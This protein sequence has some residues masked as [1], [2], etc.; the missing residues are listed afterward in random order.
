L[1]LEQQSAIQEAV[2]AASQR[3][4]ASFNKGDTDACVEAYT[5]DAS[6]QAKPLGTFRGRSTIDEFWRPFMASG[7]RDLVYKNI[8]VEIVNESIAL[9]SAEWTMNVGRGIITMEKWSKQQ[10]G[11]WRLEEDHF[12]IQEQF[13]VS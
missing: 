1:S 7:A 6:I 12:E 10:D 9:L 5:P 13:N 2:L 3:W 8:H 4:I 11:A